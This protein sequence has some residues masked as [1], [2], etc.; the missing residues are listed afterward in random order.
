[1]GSEDLEWAISELENLVKV[2][3]ERVEE[4]QGQVDQHEYWFEH[5]YNTTDWLFENTNVV[6]NPEPEPSN[7]A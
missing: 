4:L 5:E 1:M 7:D 2:L 6:M 3:T